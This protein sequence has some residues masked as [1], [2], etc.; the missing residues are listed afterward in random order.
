MAIT[1]PTTLD[2]LANPS[3]TDNLNNPSHSG[4]HS[5]ANDALEALEAKVGTDSSAVSS[6]LDYKVTNSSSSNPGHKHTLSDGASNITASAS[7]INALGSLTGSITDT[8][9]SQTLQNKTIDNPSITDLLKIRSRDA[10][11][12]MV[13]F[14]FDDGATEDYDNVFP[15]FEAQGEVGAVCIV[16]DIADAGAS[17]TWTEILEMSAAG[18]E[19]VNHSKSHANLTT[20]TEVQVVADIESSMAAFATH[21]LTPTVFAYPNNASN[22]I[23]RR[24]VRDYFQGAR[25]GGY[26]PNSYAL[27]QFNIKSIVFDDLSSITSYQRLVDRV[28]I[29]GEWL[30]FYGH[31]G[32]Y[33]A[34]ELTNLDTFIDYVQTKNVPIVTPSAAL[35]VIGNTIEAGDAFGIS[36]RGIRFEAQSV[37]PDFTAGGGAITT[38]SGVA[39]ADDQIDFNTSGTAVLTITDPI[40]MPLAASTLMFE[41][42]TSKASVDPV[43][44]ADTSTGHYIRW[45]G[46]LGALYFYQ[47]GTHYATFSTLGSYFASDSVTHI[48]FVMSATKVTCYVNGISQGENATVF[49]VPLDMDKIQNNLDTMSMKMNNIRLWHKALT[50]TEIRQEVYS[51]SAVKTSGLVKQYRGDYYLGTAGTPTSF[52]NIK[53]YDILLKP[54]L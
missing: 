38:I 3:S 46:S 33:D 21:G 2:T 36:D 49:T 24:V 8:Q 1:F 5:D 12:P 20:L 51:E 25:G 27:D 30:C 42:T 50:E 9:S 32:G 28:A 17:T 41:F 10:A 35:A 40:T 4:Q 37:F 23:V 45:R 31:T 26:V 16:T 44:F 11:T 15:I 54:Q 19:V 52:A 18:W 34:T 39:I 14:F 6:S 43:I 53:Q 47:D 7:Q 13:T 29:T 22:H 48:A